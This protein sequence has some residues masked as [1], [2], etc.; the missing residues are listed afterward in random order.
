MTLSQFEY[1][2]IIATETKRIEGDI[3]WGSDQNSLSVR[4]RHDIDSDEGFPLYLQGWYNPYSGKLSYA[5][6][7]RGVA[8]STGWISGQSTSTLTA[9]L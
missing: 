9:A 1:D 4:F 3:S 5:I 2:A 8:G 6:I 7:Y